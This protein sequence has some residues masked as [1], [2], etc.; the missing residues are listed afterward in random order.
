MLPMRPIALSLPFKI[1]RT[2]KLITSLDIRRYSFAESK[3][4][5]MG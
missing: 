2:G 3:L 4:E 1:F 5:E